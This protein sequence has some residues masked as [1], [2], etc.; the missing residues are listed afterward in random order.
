MSRRLSHGSRSFRTRSRVRCRSR[1][2]GMQGRLLRQAPH[3]WPVHRSRLALRGRWRSQVS[4][5]RR[6]PLV[7]R[8]CREQPGRLAGRLRTSGRGRRAPTTLPRQ[9][10]W[11]WGTCRSVRWPTARR[12][13]PLTARSFHVK[14]RQ[15]EMSSRPRR[16]KRP[17]HVKRRVPRRPRRRGSR[18]RGSRHRPPPRAQV[19]TTSPRASRVRGGARGRSP[20]PSRISARPTRGRLTQ[21]SRPMQRPRLTQRPRT[22]T[23][24]PAPAW[25][26]SP[27]RAPLPMSPPSPPTDVHRSPEPV[28]A[29]RDRVAHPRRRRRSRPGTA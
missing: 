19:T 14:Q 4:R 21:R 28:T 26:V 18:R 13:R 24:R 29:R 7:A 11:V 27:R 20:S 8:R 17:F 23:M 9:V 3:P 15:P 12:P 16:L 22:R 10:R 1:R 5:R 25:W 6:E 2:R